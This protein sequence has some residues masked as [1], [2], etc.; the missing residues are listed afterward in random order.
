[1]NKD[2]A[3]ISILGLVPVDAG[4][5]MTVTNEELYDSFKKLQAIEGIV[6]KYREVLK[7]T[8]FK[9]ADKIG[10]AEPSGSRVVRFEDGSGWQKQARVSQSM[11]M[12]AVE[13][14]IK[15]MQLDDLMVEAVRPAEGVTIAEILQLVKQ[16]HPEMVETTMVVSEARVEEAV[17]TGRIPR[18][19]FETMVERKTIWALVDLANA[20]K[21]GGKNAQSV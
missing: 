12:E 10:E 5:E 9:V 18:K 19:A 3:V 21:G 7:D 17:A 16:E 2:N 14:F 13:A 1:M 8:L 20:K 11:N 4:K 6:K 15:A